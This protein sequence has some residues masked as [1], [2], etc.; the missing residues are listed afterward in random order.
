MAWTYF[1]RQAEEKAVSNLY[2][3]I[4]SWGTKRE[5]L[6]AAYRTLYLALCISYFVEK[7]PRA[8]GIFSEYAE[9]KV[10]PSF[11]FDELITYIVKR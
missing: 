7:S 9:N 11:T 5:A 6:N 10:F 2:F 3:V 8:C 4:P 1:V